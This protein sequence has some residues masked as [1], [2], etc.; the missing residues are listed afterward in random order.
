ML[1][2]R[3]ARYLR[4]ELRTLEAENERLKKEVK[5][6]GSEVGSS[7]YGMFKKTIEYFGFHHAPL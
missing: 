4:D 6:L 2:G 1:L 5:D 7:R 3:D